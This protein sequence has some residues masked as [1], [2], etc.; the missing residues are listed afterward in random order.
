MNGRERNEIVVNTGASMP[1]PCPSLPIH[2]FK[3][4]QQT[5]SDIL[6]MLIF[7]S[8]LD[9]VKCPKQKLKVIH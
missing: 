5:I 7:D 9:T 8:F 3:Q 6:S 1:R 2:I 4:L